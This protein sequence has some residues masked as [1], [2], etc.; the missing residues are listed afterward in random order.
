M[1][2]AYELRGHT[3]GLGSDFRNAAGYLAREFCHELTGSRQT[4]DWQNYLA[5][6]ITSEAKKERGELQELTRISDIA[7]RGCHSKMAS[8]QFQQFG[9][10]LENLRTK[11]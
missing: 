2:A 6:R 5:A 1:R 9:R 11:N 8:Q 7:C 4:A 10:T 3:A